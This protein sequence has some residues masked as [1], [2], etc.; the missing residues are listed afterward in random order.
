VSVVDATSTLVQIPSAR[1][2]SLQLSG[3]H[4]RG[5]RAD[6]EVRGAPQSP[7]IFVFSYRADVTPLE[8]ISFGSLLT[9]IP[10]TSGPFTILPTGTLHTSLP[11]PATWPLGETYFAQAVSLAPPTNAI[12]VSNRVALHVNH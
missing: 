10:V 1:P 7:A 4:S 3:T 6:F 5:G 11:L 8:P 9:S 2:T 12:Q